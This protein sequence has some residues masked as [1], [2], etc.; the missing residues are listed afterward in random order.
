VHL[1]AAI[2]RQVLANP[3]AVVI[4]E[5]RPVTIE[6]RSSESLPTVKSHSIPPRVLSICV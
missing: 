3:L 2:G 6:K 4:A 1:D 5:G